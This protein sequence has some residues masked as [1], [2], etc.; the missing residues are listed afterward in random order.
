MSDVTILKADRWCDV[1]AGEVRSPAVIVIDGNEI[2]AVNPEELPEP[3]HPK[4]TWAT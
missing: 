2:V 3:G 1:E 4:S